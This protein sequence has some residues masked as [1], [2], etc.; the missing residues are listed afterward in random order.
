MFA[1]LAFVVYYNLINLT[2]AWIAGGKMSMG[3]A[4]IIAHGGAFLIAVGTLWW[5]EQGSSRIGWRRVVAVRPAP[6]AGR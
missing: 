2:E 1:L 5:R 4:L 3:A 6:A